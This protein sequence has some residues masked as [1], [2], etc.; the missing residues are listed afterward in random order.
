MNDLLM[1]QRRASDAAAAAAAAAAAPASAAAIAASTA[2]VTAAARAAPAT[3]P[4]TALSL[5]LSASASSFG[6][7]SC[8]AG[9]TGAGYLTKAPATPGKSPGGTLRIGIK[10]GKTA[11]MVRSRSLY[12]NY[13]EPIPVERSFFSI[14]S[15]FLFF[16]PLS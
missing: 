16:S 2:A 9:G 6:A 11:L 7:G 15:L 10:S 3:P 5:S 13:A 12:P 4:R 8:A 14:T 1:E